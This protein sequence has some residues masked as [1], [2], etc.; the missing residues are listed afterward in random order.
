MRFS[1]HSNFYLETLRVLND[2]KSIRKYSRSDGFAHVAWV[3]LPYWGGNLRRGRDVDQVS[4]EM[5]ADGSTWHTSK[6]ALTLSFLVRYAEFG[7]V[8][9]YQG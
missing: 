4:F 5:G 6:A 3:S 9:V 7:L 8:W 2:W 1:C